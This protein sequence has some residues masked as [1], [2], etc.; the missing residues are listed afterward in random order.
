MSDADLDAWMDAMSRVLDLSLADA[1]RDEVRRNL[2]VA[3]RMAA[4]LADAPLD[5]REEPLPV[6]RP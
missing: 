4:L 1:D 3:A 2:A 6:Y 5:E